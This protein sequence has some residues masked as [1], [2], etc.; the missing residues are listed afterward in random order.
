VRG[1]FFTRIAYVTQTGAGNG[2]RYAL[3]VADSDGW[4][5][6]TVVRSTEP[7]MSPSWSPDGAR[8]A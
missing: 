7:L 8:L 1:A 2:A 3:V 5:P 6:Q 4:N